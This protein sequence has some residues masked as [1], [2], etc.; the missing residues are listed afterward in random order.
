[1]PESGRAGW[2]RP[3]QWLVGLAII[4]F[5][6]RS[7]LRN[8]EALRSQPLRVELSAGW[9]A[10]SV[11]LVWAMYAVLIVAWRTMLLGWGQRLDG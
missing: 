6:A 1:V 5:A 8:W 3:A 7:L 2:V 10:A 4:A 11:L 9:L